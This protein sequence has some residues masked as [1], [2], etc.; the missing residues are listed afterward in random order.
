VSRDFKAGVRYF[1]V[2]SFLPADKGPRFADVRDVIKA[3]QAKENAHGIVL[4]LNQ[5]G[6]TDALETG[7]E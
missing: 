4:A 6:A 7:V 2:G 3:I 5:R 1:E